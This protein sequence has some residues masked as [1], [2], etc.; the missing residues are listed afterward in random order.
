MLRRSN[1]NLASIPESPEP[2]EH[3]RTR[4]D[5]TP[6]LTHPPVGPIRKTSAQLETRY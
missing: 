2:K 3:R 1:L 5:T 4:S 6:S